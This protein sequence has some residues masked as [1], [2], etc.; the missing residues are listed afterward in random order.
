MATKCET[1]IRRSMLVK[2]GGIPCQIKQNPTIILFSF[3]NYSNSQRSVVVVVDDD[4]VVVDDDDDVYAY[5]TNN[6][7]NT[8]NN[9]IIYLTWF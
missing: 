9:M 4:D 8:N 3:L 6:N 2:Y 7:T 1:T 5:T